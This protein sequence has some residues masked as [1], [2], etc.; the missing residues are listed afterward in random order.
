MGDTGNQR[1]NEP[2]H[3]RL[4]LF[5]QPPDVC[6]VRQAE[7]MGTGKRTDRTG[8]G[9]RQ[10]DGKNP[11]RIYAGAGTDGAS[12]LKKSG[13]GQPVAHSVAIPLPTRLPGKIP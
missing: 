2:V 8:N 11:G 13:Q 1:D 10:R 9:Q 4:E 6:R 5:L 3:H 12:I 7:R